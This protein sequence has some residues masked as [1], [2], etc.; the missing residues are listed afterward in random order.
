MLQIEKPSFITISGRKIAYN[1]VCPPNPIGTILLITG[2][3]S[4]RLG[5]YNQFKEFG[6]L[7]RTV[8]LDNRDVGD[9]D[10]STDNYSVADMAGDTAL[11]IKALKIENAYVVG[12]SMGGFI[13][14]ELTL[15]H[16]ELVRKLVLVSTSGGG[17][18]NVPANPRLW[19]TFLTLRNQKIERDELI[20]RVFTLITGPGYAAN[21]P[22]EMRELIALSGYNPITPQG[23]N[24]QLRACLL[25]NAAFRLDQIKV[26]TLVIHGNK[27]PL[28]P[29]ANGRR[30]ARKIAGAKINIYPGVGHLP[31]IEDFARFNRDVLAFLA[32]D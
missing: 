11:F 29:L 17:L 7:Y 19:P 8:A 14:L 21:H 20:R 1:E 23:Y 31:I 28:V 9:S 25:H 27:D 2:L 13:A 5:W 16:P 12:I 10:P 32:Q 6:G 18:T 4:N 30:L 26:P 22:E 3:A 15:R 24:R